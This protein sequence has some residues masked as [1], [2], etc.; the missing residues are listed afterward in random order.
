VDYRRNDGHRIIGF[1]FGFGVGVGGSIGFGIGGSIGFGIG[2]G[3][4]VGVGFGC[5]AAAAFA[6]ASLS[7]FA[8]CAAFCASI[9][10]FAATFAAANAASASGEF[11]PPSL[12][13]LV[14]SMSFA[15]KKVKMK[16]IKGSKTNIQEIVL[17]PLEHNQFK[18][19]PQIK[20]K[21]PLTTKVITWK[22]LKKA[23]IKLIPAKIKYNCAGVQ[24][25]VKF[26]ATII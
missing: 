8:W 3:C 17:S 9:L 14:V 12:I 23:V 2:L 18:I 20:T 10:A 7:I 4:G 6:A 15:K 22:S 26:I 16:K 24:K 19:H 5:C 13:V 21:I 11:G 1:G 25:R